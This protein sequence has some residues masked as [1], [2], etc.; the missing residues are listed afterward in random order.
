MNPGYLT[1]LNRE[2]ELLKEAGLFKTERV[3]TSPQQPHHHRLQRVF[4]S[5]W[6]IYYFVITV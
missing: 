6:Q 4:F 3:I 5:L 2:I 1:H